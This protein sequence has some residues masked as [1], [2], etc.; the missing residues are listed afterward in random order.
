MARHREHPELAQHVDLIAAHVLPYWE[1]TPV[2]DAVDFVLERAR[3]LKAAFPRKPLLLAEVGWPSNGR[4]RG[5]A[6]ATPADQAICLRRLTNALNGE[7]YSYFQSSKPSTSPGRSAPKARWVPS[8]TTPTARPSSTSPGRWCRFP[9]RALA[10]VSAVLAV[11]AF[12]PA[13][14]RQ[15]LAAPARADLPRRGLVRLR[16]GAGVDRLRLQPAVQH[17]VQP[18]RRRVAGRRRAGVVIVLFTEAHELAEAVW[19]RKRRRPF[20]P[21]TARRPIGPRCRSTCPATTSRR[22]C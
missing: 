16:L 9:R 6:E 8:V 17:L 2:A 12:T 4:M 14:D 19:T 21:I 5:S 10:I 22:N 3:E 7:G 20:L 13:A 18:D 11:L 1:A 15:F